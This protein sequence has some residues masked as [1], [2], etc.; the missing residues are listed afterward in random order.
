MITECKT[1]DTK[2]VENAPSSME[3]FVDMASM[4]ATDGAAMKPFEGANATGHLVVTIRHNGD[5]PKVIKMM[6]EA[7]I[8][9]VDQHNFTVSAAASGYDLVV[10]GAQGKLT[11]QDAEAEK[12]PLTYA[13]G[14]PAGLAE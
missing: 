12:L 10:A 2:E 1:S 4:T 3:V 14:Y 11:M 8:R 5:G 9:F 6:V 7:K 13:C